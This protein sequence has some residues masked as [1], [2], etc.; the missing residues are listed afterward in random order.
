MA[1]LEFLFTL[2]II[3]LPIGVIGRIGLGSQIFI[4]S[5]DL[6]LLCI[7]T[8]S[9]LYFIKKKSIPHPR[10]IFVSFLVFFILFKNFQ[11]LH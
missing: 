7:F 3:S 5:H 4:Y 1:L 6:I 2:F 9:T 10:N 11:L 8:I